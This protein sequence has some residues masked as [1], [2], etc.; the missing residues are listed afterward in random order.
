MTIMNILAPLTGGQSDEAVMRN[1]FAASKPVGGHVRALFVRPDPAQ[2]M[3]YFGDEMVPSIVQEIVDTSRR[4]SDKA[5]TAARDVVTRTAQEAGAQL[6]ETP[7]PGNT[8][9]FRE[10][11]GYF[12]DCVARVAQLADLVVFGPLKDGGRPGM[13]EAFEAVLVETGRPA[14]LSSGTPPGDFAGRIAI[15]WNASREGAHAISAALPYL[16]QAKA[17]EILTVRSGS[18]E[19]PPNGDVLEYLQLHGVHAGV[20]VVDAG[21]RGIGQ[22]LLDS[23][24][25]GHADLLVAGSYGR[26]RLREIF[27]GGV[28]RQILNQATLPLFLMR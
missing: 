3:P 14:L 12:A 15:G 5:A 9:S 2:A 18:V 13:T 10:I 25:E 23:A 19:P 6:V 17:V 7:A 20:R 1:A 28:M 27:A 4:A 8:V 26:R 11:Q 21:D 22:A 24:G 16:T